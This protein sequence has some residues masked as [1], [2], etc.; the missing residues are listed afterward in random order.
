MLSSNTSTT[1]KRSSD[2]YRSLSSS[3]AVSNRGG[4]ASRS[5]SAGL[6]GATINQGHLPTVSMPGQ[7]NLS[8]TKSDSYVRLMTM[9]R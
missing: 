7:V 1:I 2:G 6:R 5:A 8:A 9:N 4:M 3:Y